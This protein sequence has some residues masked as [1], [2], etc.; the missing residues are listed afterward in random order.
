MRID[1][2]TLVLGLIGDPV[3][4]TLSPLIHNTFAEKLHINSAYLPF[5]VRNEEDALE[6]AVHGAFS[7]GITGLNVTVPYKTEVIKYLVSVDPLAAKIGAVNTLVRTSDGY[8][9]C[10][11]DILGLERDLKRH[12]VCLEKLS[13]VLIIGA[14]GAA[15]AA[16]CLCGERGVRSL[17]VINRSYERAKALAEDLHRYFPGM[18]IV[19]LSDSDN[20]ARKLPDGILAIQCT[21]AGLYPDTDTLPVQ[22]GEIYRRIGFAYDLIYTPKETAFLKKCR[23]S[24]REGTECVNGTG[25][26]LYQAAASYERW[27]QAAGAGGSIDTG[28]LDEIGRKLFLQTGRNT[29]GSIVL[30]GFMGSGKTTVGKEL[31]EMLGLKLLDTDCIIEQREGRSIN[32]IFADE[33]EAYFRDLETGLLR[34]LAGKDRQEAAV[35][36]TGGGIVLRD[37]NRELLHK[38]GTVVWLR[39]TAADVVRRLEGDSTRPLLEGEDKEQRIARLIAMREDLYSESADIIID[40]GSL[41]A[42]KIAAGIMEKTGYGGQHE[43]SGDQRAES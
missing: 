3:E 15:R 4:H 34:E 28:I 43:N 2:H 33:G 41:T 29:Q 17:Y 27:M 38:A 21:S 24:G 14:G 31:A 22:S 35:Y 26:L 36:A 32:E 18:E 13:E 11:T 39:V 20:D 1:G 40:A 23:S 25:M 16:A 9:G 42:R 6:K 10:N 12:G 37:E 5:H 8:T 30:T 19:L 7:L